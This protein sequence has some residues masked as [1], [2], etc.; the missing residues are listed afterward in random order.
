MEINV[1]IAAF[2]DHESSTGLGETCSTL[3]LLAS[4]DVDSLRKELHD[5]RRRSGRRL[6][7]D[8]PPSRRPR[9]GIGPIDEVPGWRDEFV[10]RSVLDET[11][12]ILLTRVEEI[13]DALSALLE[14]GTDIYDELKLLCKDQEYSTAANKVMIRINHIEAL[15]DWTALHFAP[16]RRVTSIEDGMLV[17]SKLHQSSED[18]LERYSSDAIYDEI[19]VES[20]GMSPEDVEVFEVVSDGE[21]AH[22]GR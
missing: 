20:D 10:R 3:R 11:V 13:D 12:P 19:N 4:D 1:G 14:A 18:L 6:R 16:N 17:I 7:F 21:G 2:L 22:R 8:G 9:G 5:E 15:A